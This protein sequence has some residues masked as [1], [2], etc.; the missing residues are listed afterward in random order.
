MVQKRRHNDKYDEY[1]FT[2]NTS[3]NLCQLNEKID[4]YI[5]IQVLAKT[6]NYG[7]YTNYT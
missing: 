3:L 5:P 6:K 2:Q 4:F 1:K 7:R